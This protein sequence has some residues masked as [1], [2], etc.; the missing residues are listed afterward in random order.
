MSKEIR[1]SFNKA[2]QDFKNYPYGFS[3]S[4]DFSIKESQVLESNG[5]WLAALADGKVEPESEEER[6]LISVIVGDQ[7][8]ESTLE[9][10]WIK[11]QKRISRPHVGALSS[12]G[13]SSDDDGDDDEPLDLDD[14][15]ED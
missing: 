13:I 15:S 10:V 8:P 7:L 12:R 5:V 2:F 3:R 9:R 1:S 14:D 11:Y 4:G 6:R